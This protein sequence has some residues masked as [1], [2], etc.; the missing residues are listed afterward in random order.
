MTLKPT[1]LNG[2]HVPSVSAALL[3]QLDRQELAAVFS[4]LSTVM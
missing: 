4:C 1:A 2:G 3:F